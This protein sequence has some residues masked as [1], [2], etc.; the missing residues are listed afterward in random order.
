MNSSQIFEILEQSSF[1]P[2][3]PDGVSE[4]FTVLNNP[5]ITDIDELINQIYKYEN[6]SDLLLKNINSG[7]FQLGRTINSL[8]ESVVYLGL[9]NVQSLLIASIT[10]EILPNSLGRAKKFKRDL[11][12][13][14]SLGTAIAAEMICEQSNFSN[15][16]NLFSYG[17]VHD[18]GIA[19]LDK[20]LP[21]IVDEFYEHQLKGMHQIIAEKIV[22]GGITHENI[23]LWICEKWNFPNEMHAIVGYHHRPLLAKE[24]IQEVKI[25]HVADMISTI[26]YE[27]L[28]GIT[29]LQPDINQSILLSLKITQ[30]TIKHIQSKLP[31]QVEKA[32][33]ILTFKE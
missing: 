3:L 15:R 6:L 29:T 30:D 26:Y 20:C 11:Y 12:W 2:S 9:K 17:L 14:H 25:F 10:K 32:N 21:E 33:R 8:Q 7:Y 23:G 24:F 31:I 22:M 27:S 4:I 19:I 16:Y 1:I 28:L 5:A 13:K 18:I